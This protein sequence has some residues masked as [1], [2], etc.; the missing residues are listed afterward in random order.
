MNNERDEKR[1]EALIRE[2]AE[3]TKGL[4]A[5]EGLRASNRRRIENA[6]RSAN[7]GGRTTDWL[8]RRISVPLPAAA[9]FLLIFCLQLTLQL[10]DLRTY[11]RTP[12]ETASTETDS[13]GLVEEPLQLH[14]S[15]QTVYVAGMG[16]VER[17][18]NYA[19]LRENDHEGN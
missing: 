1:D 14:Y 13:I 15:E 6:L 19:Y 12:E 4:K 8:R 10:S 11:L 16:F 17:S 2:F 5:P 7:A 9:G 18:K 3:S